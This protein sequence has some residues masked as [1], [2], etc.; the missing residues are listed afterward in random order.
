MDKQVI[1][2]IGD[3]MNF[4]GIK[5]PLLQITKRIGS[6]EQAKMANDEFKDEVNRRRKELAKMYHPDHGGDAEKMKMINAACDFLMA[7]TIS[8]APPV[9]RQQ[10]VVHYNFGF[11]YDG[12]STTSSYT[13]YTGS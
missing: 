5:Y 6:H 2:K 13:Y 9:Q 8:Y 10:F 7:V 4:L 11:S 1:N 12:G 3:A